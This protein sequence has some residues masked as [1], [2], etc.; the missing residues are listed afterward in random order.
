MT[1]QDPPSNND[2]NDSLEKTTAEEAAH[3]FHNVQPNE[4]VHPFFRRYPP[5]IEE[6][7]G[8]GGTWLVSFTDVMALMLTF[9]VLMYAM[10]EPDKKYWIEATSALKQELHSNYGPPFKSGIVERISLNRLS[11]RSALDLTYLHNLI[12][13]LKNET[14]ALQSMVIST[15][16]DRLII[17]LP[18]ELLFEPGQTELNSETLHSVYTLGT[19][20]SRLKNAVSV[21]GYTD[22]APR[23]S[24]TSSNWGLSLAR[25]AAVAGLLENA[26]YER[27]IAIYGYGES[28]MPNL[29]DDLP[30]EEKKKLARRVD[31][32]IEDHRSG[33]GRIG[34]F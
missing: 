22:D 21:I 33:T 5:V 12:D 31:L 7:G 2:P 8:F 18:E 9:F 14:P 34:G 29:P 28:V 13:A 25:A 3:N 16:E 10:S 27:P 6:T 24:G 32:A 26:G 23:T 17:S 30:A 20:L 4:G 15:T 11:S 19:L 1:M